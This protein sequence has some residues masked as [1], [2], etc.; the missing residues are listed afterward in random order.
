MRNRTDP[1]IPRRQRDRLFN[2]MNDTGENHSQTAK[3]N[4]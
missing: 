1:M 4:R 3:G 2:K